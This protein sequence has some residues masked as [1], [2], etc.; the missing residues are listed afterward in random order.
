MAADAERV[1]GLDDRLRPDE[2][3][4]LRVHRVVGGHEPSFERD[5][6]EIRLVVV[7]HAPDSV[8]R[9]DGDGLRVELRQRGDALAHGRREDDRLE[10]R[11]RLP[12]RL[13]CEVELA[14]AEVAAPEH[15]LDRAGPGVDRD[16]RR[17]GPVGVPEHLLDRCPGLLL[18]L[19][20]D[21]GRDV[22]AASEHLARAVVVDELVLHVVDEVLRLAAG[23]GQPHRIRRGKLGAVGAPEVGRGDL[24]LLEHHVEDV[25]PAQLRVARMRHRVVAGRVGRKPGE[26][27]RLVQLEVQRALL[28]VRARSLLDTVGAVAEVDRVQ[29][30]GED[31]VLRPRLLELPGERGLAHL[32]GKRPLVPDVRVLHELLRD[33]GSALHDRLAADVRPE[34]ACHAT[35]VDPVVLEEAA[36]LD[37]DDRLPH[38]RRDL[39]GLDEDSALLTAQHGEDRSAV[40]R[41][42][43]G[44]DLGALCGRI[45]RRDL[46]RDGADEPER[47]RE[48][49]KN[50]QKPDERCQPP[51]TN[52]PPPAGRSLLLP[53]LQA[54][55]SRRRYTGLD[56]TIGSFSETSTPPAS[57]SVT[58]TTVPARPCP[59]RA[60]D[61]GRGCRR[62]ALR[63]SH[64]RPR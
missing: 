54:G 48:Q 38:D 34:R 8:A 59:R 13:R 5:A 9:V 61:R 46:A 12:L 19:Q 40:G 21:R 28:E 49:G 51:L 36:I 27:R 56:A 23:S 58:A 47:E 11:A 52:P 7:R 39:L 29:V 43:D 14:L 6:A 33:R 16:E 50:E 45:E 4:E 24:P 35:Q 41:V 60:R 25:A 10:R 64:S 62:R 57:S 20:V 55:E 18:Q 26:E 30:G 42:D 53:Y 31:A 15:G 22:Q 2:I 17:R 32:P 3:G 37:R 44:V 1:G 63:R